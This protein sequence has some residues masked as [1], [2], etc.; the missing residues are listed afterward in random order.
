[1]DLASITI[2]GV[3]TCDADGRSGLLVCLISAATSAQRWI[4]AVRTVDLGGQQLLQQFRP[5]RSGRDPSR[6]PPSRWLSRRCPTASLHRAARPASDLLYSWFSYP[7]YGP[8]RAVFSQMH[9]I[10]ADGL[11]RMVVGQLGPGDI[12]TP[13]SLDEFHCGV[14]DLTRSFDAAPVCPTSRPF[15]RDNPD[16]RLEN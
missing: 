4:P 3:K 8:D 15:G 1:M 7:Q 13:S 10:L 6:A 16:K 5:V 11:C 12:P 9:C 14:C 2:S